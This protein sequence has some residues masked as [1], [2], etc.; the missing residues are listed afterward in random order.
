MLQVGC[1]AAKCSPGA[2]VTACAQFIGSKPISAPTRDHWD[3]GKL[4]GQ[5]SISGGG[6]RSV[7]Q[8]MR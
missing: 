7:M 3:G 2:V 5:P 1:Q 4:A 8:S 6:I